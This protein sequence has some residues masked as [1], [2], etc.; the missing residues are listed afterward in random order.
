M[1]IVRVTDYPAQLEKDTIYL[2]ALPEGKLEM[3]VTST[4]DPAVVHTLTEGSGSG[5][6]G[7]T[8]VYTTELTHAD[9]MMLAGC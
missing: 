1:N 5:G 6:S 9:V 7:G 4:N 2:K 8:T 3:K